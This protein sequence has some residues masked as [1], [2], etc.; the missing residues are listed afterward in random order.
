V[1]FTSIEIA[2]II[3][4]PPGETPERFFFLDIVIDSLKK[5]LAHIPG[6]NP[7]KGHFDIWIMTAPFGRS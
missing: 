5:E 7:E 1:C 3:M 6:P 4:L 2:D